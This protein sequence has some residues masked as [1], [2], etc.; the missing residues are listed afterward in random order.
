MKIRNFLI[1]LALGSIVLT[2]FGQNAI[3]ATGGT[4]GVYYPL[5]QD[6][7]SICGI[8]DQA[9]FIESG[10]SLDNHE[11]IWARPPLA[12]MGIFQYDF[13]LYMLERDPR[14]QRSMSVV[15]RLHDEYLQ[16][17]TLNQTIKDGGW[18]VPGFGRVGGSSRVLQSF[19]D[20]KGQTVFAWGGSFYSANVLSDKFGLGLNVV[21]VSGTAPDGKGGYMKVEKGDRKSVV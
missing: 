17:I 18:N 6:L 16:V 11:K 20:L 14:W 7:V 8:E 9:K 13:A 4:K 3:I 12:T 5:G 2:S 15:A 1:A 10:G 19:N 21:D